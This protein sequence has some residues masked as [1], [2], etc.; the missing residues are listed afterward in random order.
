MTDEFQIYT[1]ILRFLPFKI[2]SNLVRIYLNIELDKNKVI[3]T[4][5]YH[6][7]PTELEI[8]LFD[9]ICTNSKAHL[10]NLIVEGKVKTVDEF[11]DNDKYD[12]VVFSIYESID[13]KDG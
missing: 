8:E 9:D 7:S 10:P 3:L 1:T 12:F 6:S 13:D 4:S 2:T 5:F 11:N